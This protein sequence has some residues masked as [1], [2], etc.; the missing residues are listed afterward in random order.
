MKWSSVGFNAAV[1]VTVRMQPESNLQEA[2]S[3]PPARLL[4]TPNLALRLQTLRLRRTLHIRR[5]R[6]GRD[7]LW[8]GNFSWDLKHVGGLQIG[9]SLNADWRQPMDGT[10]EA[11]TSFAFTDSSGYFA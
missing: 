2:T 6:Q 11:K 7:Q 10:S 4:G 3:R 8:Q 9:I 1:A 5:V